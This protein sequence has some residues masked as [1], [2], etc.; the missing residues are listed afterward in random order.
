MSRWAEF[1]VLLFALSCGACAVSPT[2]EKWRQKSDA[3]FVEQLKAAEQAKTKVILAAFALNSESNAF[4]S[5]A[6]LARDTL[7]SINPRLSVL[8]LSNHPQ[9]SDISYPFATK[10]NIELALAYIGKRTDKDSLVVVLLSSHGVPNRL[11]I[12]IAN[13]DYREDLWAHEL[14]GYLDPLRQVP[15]IVIISACFSGSFVRPLASERR[16]IITSAAP[17]RS[18][19]GCHPASSGTY[20]IQALLP[21]DLNSALSLGALFL[22]ARERVTERE[23]AEGLTPSQPQIYVGKAMQGF[24][25]APFQALLDAQ[26]SP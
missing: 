17:D 25:N 4:Q 14:I 1:A 3:L 26:R 18:S 13:G 5:D 16:I 24:A 8:L 7:R 23:K 12:D 15:T 9:S 11:A 21:R 2:S 6:L 20:F 10:R 22:R 19:F